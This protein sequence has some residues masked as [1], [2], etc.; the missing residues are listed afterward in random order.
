M[1]L[2]KES[3]MKT[4]QAQPMPICWVIGPNV[5]MSA[6]DHLRSLGLQV[7]LADE[8]PSQAEWAVPASFLCVRDYEP[9]VFRRWRP[10]ADFHGP[11]WQSGQISHRSNSEWSE[12]LAG[13][14]VSAFNLTFS[15]VVD[16]PRPDDPF[17]YPLKEFKTVAP[18]AVLLLTRDWAE[19]DQLLAMAQQAQLSET[20]LASPLAQALAELA[21][22]FGQIA[23]IRSPFRETEEPLPWVQFE[24]QVLTLTELDF[25]NPQAFSNAVGHSIWRLANNPSEYRPSRL[26]KRKAW[27]HIQNFHPKQDQIR[28]GLLFSS[29]KNADLAQE[30]VATRPEMLVLSWDPVAFSKFVVLTNPNAIFFEQSLV[31][32]PEHPQLHPQE[33]SNQGARI[34]T[35]LTFSRTLLGLMPPQ[36]QAAGLDSV[37]QELQ[38]QTDQEPAQMKKLFELLQQALKMTQECRFQFHLD[39][40]FTISANQAT[41]Q[42]SPS[43]QLVRLYH[44]GAT[45]CVQWHGRISSDIIPSWIHLCTYCPQAPDEGDSAIYVHQGFE[46]CATTPNM[47]IYSKPVA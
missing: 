41:F 45:T 17:A 47:L 36:W 20:I 24:H 43:R 16:T 40:G 1:S 27:G 5:P 7:E 39:G 30:L 25:Q 31:H 6:V 14:T 29:Q 2:R 28:L 21:E 26:G 42:W 18:A 23:T 46:N 44:Q 11:R 37:L 22:Q 38:V 35:A 12:Q 19:V 15:R 33:D 13:R 10:T 8:L 3:Q 9:S 34:N 4:S 32:F